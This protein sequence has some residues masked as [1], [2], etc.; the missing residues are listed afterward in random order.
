VQPGGIGEQ[1]V[2]GGAHPVEQGVGGGAHLVEQGVGGGAH[3]VQQGVGGGAH[4]VQ[5]GVGGGAFAPPCYD[6]EGR[7]RWP[8]FARTREHQTAYEAYD[9]ELIV[10]LGKFVKITSKSS[11]YYDFYIRSDLVNFGMSFYLYVYLLF[12]LVT[13]F[14]L[15]IY[16][17]I[18]FYPDAKK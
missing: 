6:D 3:P 2:G 10:R 17:Y 18:Y 1:G 4:P 16:I 9:V 15:C 12:Y 14:S 8:S 13:F 11:N 5:Q 7:R